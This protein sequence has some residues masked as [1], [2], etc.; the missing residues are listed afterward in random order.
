MAYLSIADQ[1]RNASADS[2]FPGP[3][4]RLTHLPNRITPIV[5]ILPTVK[6]GPAFKRA[7][8]GNRKRKNASNT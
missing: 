3:L 7:P 5:S 8:A 2:A 6:Q 4:F 1:K